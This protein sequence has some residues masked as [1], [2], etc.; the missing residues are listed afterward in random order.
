MVSALIKE[1]LNKDLKA[2]AHKYD[3][4]RSEMI[5][6]ACEEKVEKEKSSS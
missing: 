5:R 6:I 2:L 1:K 4:S 3:V